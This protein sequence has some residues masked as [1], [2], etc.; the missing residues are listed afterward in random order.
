[1]I[2]MQAQ[3]P[4]RQPSA[5][6]VNELKFERKYR[7]NE[8]T[9]E[10]IM[11]EESIKEI[12]FEYREFVTFVRAQ[13]GILAGIDHKLGEEFKKELLA[14][15]ENA[16]KA[17][18]EVK[19]ILEKSE[20]AI[21]IVTDKLNHGKRVSG[22]KDFLAKKESDRNLGFFKA[23]KDNTKEEDWKIL[24]EA[25]TDEERQKLVHCVALLKR[26]GKK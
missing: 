13:E 17:L 26:Q 19:P 10:V 25:L 16:E 22:M 12:T 24:L 15:K 18:G 23:F 21:K 5:K 8:E 4:S 14:S 3:T 9:A 7:V 11:T 20:A 2:N 1:V 6:D